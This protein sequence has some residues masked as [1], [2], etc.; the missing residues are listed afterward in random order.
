MTTGLDAVMAEVAVSRDGNI[1]VR[2]NA[3][4]MGNGSATSLAIAT[5]AILGQ[6]ARTIVMGDTTVLKPALGLDTSTLSGKNWTD[7]RWTPTM[8]GSS[9]ACVTAFHQVHA[10]CQT[11]PG[12]APF[13]S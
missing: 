4:D 5:G 6:N 1:S 9:G 2:T 8:P 3:V 7:P 10:V 11:P 13:A 12:T